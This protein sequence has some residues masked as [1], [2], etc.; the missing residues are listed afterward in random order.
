M[1]SEISL[2]WIVSEL[3]LFLFVYIVKLIFQQFMSTLSGLSVFFS[4]NRLLYISY[5]SV[6]IYF[7]SV[8]I[9]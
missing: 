8:D 4:T 3:C 9:I 1:P 2:F 5:G 6:P 7:L